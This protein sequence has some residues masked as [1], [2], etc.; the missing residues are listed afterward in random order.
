MAAHSRFGRPRLRAGGTLLRMNPLLHRKS[1]PPSEETGA[2]LIRRA[3]LVDPLQCDCEGTFRVIAFITDAKAIRNILSHLET[4]T[5][6]SRA[7]P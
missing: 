5:T 4:R 1:A 3:Y 2:Y 7:P 6:D